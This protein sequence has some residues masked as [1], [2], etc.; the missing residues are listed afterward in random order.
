[1]STADIP[2]ETPA[3]CSPGRDRPGWEYHVADLG[4]PMDAEGLDRLGH[5][6]W[7]LCAVVKYG[8]LLTYHFK[9]PS[10]GGRP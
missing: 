4:G 6:G 9:R 1:M 2:A 10:K 3:A 7:E 8:G 5:E